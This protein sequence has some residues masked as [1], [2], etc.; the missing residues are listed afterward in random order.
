MLMEF[1]NNN[2][3]NFN[4]SFWSLSFFLQANFLMN[5]LTNFIESF[6]KELLNVHKHLIIFLINLICDHHS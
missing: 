4:I 5:H 1:K 6:G 3:S 2:V